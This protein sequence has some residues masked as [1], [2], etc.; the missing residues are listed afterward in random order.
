M[1]EDRVPHPKKRCGERKVQDPCIL[2][3]NGLV[4]ILQTFPHL[5]VCVRTHIPVLFLWKWQHALGFFLNNSF[6]ER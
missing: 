1:L 3:V 6:I 5:H 2:V 4:Y